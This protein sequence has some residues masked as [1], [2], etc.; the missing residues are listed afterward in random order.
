MQLRTELLNVINKLRRTHGEDIAQ[1]IA[2]AVLEGHLPP[3]KVYKR[4]NMMKLRERR[5][6]KRIVSASHAQAF[7]ARVYGVEIEDN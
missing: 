4:A 2:L 6:N 3:D 1:S 5:L 7:L